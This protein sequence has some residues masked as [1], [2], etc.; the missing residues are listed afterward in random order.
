MSEPLTREELKH[1]KFV[2][3][4]GDMELSDNA[5]RKRN[6]SAFQILNRAL[7]DLEALEKHHAAD[8]EAQQAAM[9]KCIREERVSKQAQLEAAHRKIDE[10][11][12]D[13]A[14]IR[15]QLEWCESERDAARTRCEQQAKELDRA[16]EAIRENAAPR[17]QATARVESLMARCEQQSDQLEQHA[18]LLLEKTA[19]CGQLEQLYSHKDLDFECAESGCKSTRSNKRC[20]QLEAA[21]ARLTDAVDTIPAAVMLMGGPPYRLTFTEGALRAI[22][23]A[24]QVENS[25]IASETPAKEP[26]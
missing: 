17:D 14:E 3:W 20:E 4:Q 7:N 8:L 12:S 11:R 19:R 5:L 10:Q 18:R 2:I 22:A 25:T 15:A 1:W 26:A 13:N 6:A 24:C 9:L 21:L 23:E 16:R